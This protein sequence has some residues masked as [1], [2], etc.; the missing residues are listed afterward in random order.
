MLWIAIVYTHMLILSMVKYINKSLSQ[1]WDESSA[2]FF[3]RVIT[4]QGNDIKHCSYSNI[5]AVFF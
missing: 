2:L 4:D 5:A 1:K 3:Y